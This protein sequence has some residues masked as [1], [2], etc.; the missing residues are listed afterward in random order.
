MVT[1]QATAEARHVPLQ[2]WCYMDIDP[3]NFV[4]IG[5]PNWSGIQTWFAAPADISYEELPDS[6]MINIIPTV[7]KLACGI[8]GISMYCSKRILDIEAR[9]SEATGTTRDPTASLIEGSCRL[10]CRRIGHCPLG[11]TTTLGFGKLIQNQRS[12]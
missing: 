12:H 2:T 4:L 7:A 3:L 10:A 9:P 11:R 6:I 8:A 5:I 1:V